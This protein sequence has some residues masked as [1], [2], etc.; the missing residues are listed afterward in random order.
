MYIVG[1]CLIYSS[2]FGVEAINSF[3]R[4][5]DISDTFN[6]FYFVKKIR[7]YPSDIRVSENGIDQNS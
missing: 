2:V 4:S 6:L 1:F 3:K 7:K 5:L